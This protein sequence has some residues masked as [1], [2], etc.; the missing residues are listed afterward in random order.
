MLVLSS[1]DRSAMVCF[2]DGRIRSPS[3]MPHLYKY[4]HR[5]IFALPHIML[6]LLHSVIGIVHILRD[7]NFLP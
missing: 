7:F 6:L 2:L 3:S 5:W 1:Q 4:L